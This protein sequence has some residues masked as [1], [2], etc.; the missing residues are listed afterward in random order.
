M[1]V[2]KFMGVPVGNLASIMQTPIE[3]IGDIGGGELVAGDLAVVSIGKSGSSYIASM[4]RMTITS[5]GSNAVHGNFITAKYGAGGGSNG[6]NVRG[7]FLGGYNSSGSV[8]Q[9]IEYINIRSAGDAGSYGSSVVAAHHGGAAATNGINDRMVSANG[10]TG[11]IGAT[12]IARLEWLT[13]SSGSSSTDFGASTLARG[14]SMGCSNA[15][16][17]RFIAGGGYRTLVT[18]SLID[19]LTINTASACTSWGDLSGSRHGGGSTDNAEND[20]GI[21]S[22]GANS[23]TNIISSIEY[24]TISVSGSSA[25]SGFSLTFSLRG[26]AGVSNKTNEAALF[27]G[28]QDGNEGNPQTVIHACTINSLANATVWGNLLQSGGPEC[29]GVN[30]N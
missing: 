27:A 14:G 12:D 19:T 26:P 28:G 21:I 8:H 1:A 7:V 5:P 30:D 24:T 25:N 4:E 23:A 6:R 20:R 2:V 13:I 16:G 18:R 15:T 3:D 22:G 11:T 10:S 9:G 29:E 17:E